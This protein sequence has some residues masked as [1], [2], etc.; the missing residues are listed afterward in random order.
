MHL[1][2]CFVGKLPAYAIDTIHQLRLFYDGDVSFIINDFESTIHKE[3]E[4]KYGVQI[5]NYNDVY[6]KEFNDVVDT[7]MHK[8]CIV[9]NLH[10]REKLFIY[11]FER[12]FLLHN[13]MKFKHLTN[14][15]FVE[16][17]NLLYD[18][19]RN[20]ESSFC[21]NDIAYMYD[22]KDRCASGICFVK[23]T[24]ILKQMNAHFLH[25]IQ[26]STTF[27]NEMTALH[28]FME[29]QKENVQIIPTHWIS[30]SVPEITYTNYNKYNDSIFDAAAMGI[31]LAGIDPHHSNGVITKGL[32]SIWS[33]IDYT[34]YTYNWK[35]DTRGRK[36]PYVYNESNKQWLRIN[37][38]HIHSKQLS[39]CFSA[40]IW[41]TNSVM[42]GEKF[43]QLCDVY[44]GMEYK[45]YANPKIEAEP[46]KHMHLSSLNAEWDNPPLIFC[47]GDGLH[48]LLT[49]IHF[50]KN[51]FILISHNSD[52]NITSIHLPILEHK[53]LLRWF[54]QNIMIE[55]RKL[56][57]L[58][59]GI[60][61]EMWGHG[62]LN[63][64]QKVR[65]ANNTKENNVYFYF[66]VDTNK[67][68]RETC[69]QIVSS[70]GLVFG[71]H[72]SHV[73]YLQNLS[74]C[75]F[76]IN[77]PGNGVD[78][79]R[80]WECYYLNVIPIV[81]RSPFTELL[82]KYLPCIV[83]SSWDEFNIS[84]ILP[85]YNTL[86]SKLNQNYIDFNYYKALIQLS[87]KCLQHKNSGLRSYSHVDNLTI[88][89]DC[90][91]DSL[92]NK[93][94]GFYIE[95]GANDGLTQSN[96]A[97]F[98]FH[99]NWSGVLIEPSP[100]AFE[101]CRVNRPKSA[102]F[103]YACVADS[104]T[105]FISGD[106]N[107]NLMS[108]ID[109]KRCGSSQLVNVPCTTLESILDKIGGDPDIDFMSL[110]VGGYELEILKGL[111]L[112][113]YTPNFILIEIYNKDYTNIIRYMHDHN[114]ACVLNFSNYNRIDNPHWDGEHNDYLF[115]HNYI[116][117]V[118]SP[119]IQIKQLNHPS[120][121]IHSSWFDKTRFL[122]NIPQPACVLIDTYDRFSDDLPNIYIQIEPEAILPV[123]DLIIQNAH[124]YHT[125]LTFN[126]KILEKCPNAK[127]YIYGTTFLQKSYYECI[128]TDKKQFRISH[129][130]G[131]KN[132]NNASGH[133]FRQH[134]HHNQEA[135]RH[136]PITFYR[137][138]AQVP[139]ITDYGNNPFLDFTSK[140]Q[141]FDLYQFSIVVENSRQTNYFTEKIMDC[142]LSKTIPIYYGCPN[143]SEFFDTR[144]WIIL[145]STEIE[146]LFTKLAD[147]DE[148]YYVRHKDIV[149][150][151]SKTALQYTDLIANINKAKI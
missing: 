70:K 64:L 102:C 123:E 145:E 142:V 35:S 121:I 141:L 125:I 54:A 131:S 39:D 66:S 13:L 95:L 85:Q 53:N 101:K 67:T 18:D 22:N 79:H 6:D 55:H 143:I 45:Y 56:H 146:E 130:A 120:T 5:V 1:V 59:I 139:H 43:Q 40:P 68:E 20:W 88:S 124:R 99:R 112:E 52:I 32:K 3:L 63:V 42:S 48:E 128:N 31:Y 106:F 118:P 134:I 60:A 127:R 8:F 117:N 34:H 10:G 84:N 135:L 2:Y 71:T 46:H 105:E 72:Q 23:Q 137:S 81:I 140:T 26:T 36:I 150:S 109:G 38:L 16:L 122:E 91:L 58:P 44:L 69:K 12:F 62:N 148:T 100:S 29:L 133:L 89:L 116:L 17:D 75:K 144:G 14:V 96:T 86:I 126:S 92:F 74:K 19:P 50:L 7:Y 104:T 9:H 57:L 113:K 65:E 114:Y 77:P 151:N 41:S 97:F 147:L 28:E 37:N 61:N 15:F 111:K 108:S 87:S 11:S 47:Y 136:Y 110:D 30:N 103:N 51:P 119:T 115:V 73:D 21:T 76:A 149:E 82:S 80:I 107:G 78:C 25:Y 132:H 129:L 33:I 94:N 83:L 90:K 98:E 93:S 24:D 138:V 4:S 49:K 27:I